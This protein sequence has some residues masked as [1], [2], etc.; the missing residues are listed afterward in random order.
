MS[1]NPFKD[2]QKDFKSYYFLEKFLQKS[3]AFKYQE[4]V[5][6]RLDSETKCTYQYI[7]IV[8]TIA[9][10]IE[11]PTFC[12]EKP[13]EDGMLRGVKDGSAYAENTYFQNNREALTIELYSDAVE[14]NNALGASRGMHKIV[15]VYFSLAELPK[16]IRSKAENKFLVL[17][18]KN[19]HL[20]NHRQEIY[21][22]LLEDLK[23][24]EEGVTVNG[25]VIKAGLLCHLGDNLEAHIVAGMKQS[26]SAGFVCRQCHTQHADLQK[27]R[28]GQLLKKLAHI[29]TIQIWLQLFR[30]I[31][32]YIF[33][34]FYPDSIRIRSVLTKLSK[35]VT[36][37][38]YKKIFKRFTCFKCFGS[39]SAW[40]RINMV[41][42]DPL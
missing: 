34:L 24:L 21:K 31:Q 6:I 36:G 20:K 30:F 3:P 28:Y 37:T 13:S 32:I 29:Q 14:L 42:L 17:S 18:V 27:I 41:T 23:K 33:F 26:F 4:P 5:E 22:P 7:S 25:R 12:P 39:G 35:L 19:I 40:I 11:D 15:N 38:C 9:T 8:D 16:C 10:I 1:S 2:L